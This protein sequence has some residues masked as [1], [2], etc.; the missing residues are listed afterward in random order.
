MSDYVHNKVVRLPFPKSILEKCNTDDIFEC[1]KYLTELLGDLWSVRGRNGFDIGYTD[2]GYYLDW[3]YYHTY[4]ENSGDFGNSR[5][6][7]SSELS[8][9]KPCFNKLNVQYNDE[10]LRV[11]EYCYYNGCEAPD[12]YDIIMEDNDDS[13][14]FIK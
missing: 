10:D 6:L 14:L 1:E 5:L 8:V 9:I 4:G 12:Y 3:V 13:K 2:S 11:V 7:T